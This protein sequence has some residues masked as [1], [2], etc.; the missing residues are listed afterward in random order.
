MLPIH[1]NDVD[2]ISVE[3]GESLVINKEQLFI[4]SI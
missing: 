3:D 1:G 2:S 4:S